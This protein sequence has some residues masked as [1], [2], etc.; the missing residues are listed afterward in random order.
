MAKRTVGDIEKI[1][2][3]VEGVKKLSDR[4]VG[5]GPFGVGLDGLVTWVPILGTVYSV[6]AGGW[7]LYLATQARATPGTLA[8]MAAYL[9]LDVATSE[10]PIAG[11]IVDF[12]FPGHLMAARALQKEM[13]ATHWVEDSEAAAKAAGRHEENLAHVNAQGN[14]RRLVY[15]HD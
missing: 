11:D 7:L 8:R 4:V 13:E 5:V 10:I 15:L 9:G 6:G 1:W 3:H 2:G 14:L 12:L